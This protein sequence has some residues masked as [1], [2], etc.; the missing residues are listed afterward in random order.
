MPVFS[1][2]EP[3]PDRRR[4]DAGFRNADGILGINAP[5]HTTRSLNNEKLPFRRLQFY[6]WN[7]RRFTQQNA[8]MG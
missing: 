1:L 3:R 7:R 2:L 6:P 8:G 4:S 5:Y